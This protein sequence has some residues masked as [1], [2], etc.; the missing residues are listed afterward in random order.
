MHIYILSDAGVAVEHVTFFNFMFD[1]SATT[2]LGLI[3]GFAYISGFVIA[4][5]LL[6]MFFFTFSFVRRN[7]Y[8]HVKNICTYHSVYIHTLELE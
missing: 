5:I 6:T 7:G 4:I 2:A 3:P 8:F 1:M